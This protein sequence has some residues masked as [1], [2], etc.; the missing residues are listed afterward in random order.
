M[1]VV[2]DLSKHLTRNTCFISYENWASYDHLRPIFLRSGENN[3]IILWPPPPSPM[4][5]TSPGPQ[6]SSEAGYEP[7]LKCPG[8][9]NRLSHQEGLVDRAA[10]SPHLH[11]PRPI[12][13][14]YP[15]VTNGIPCRRAITAILS[16]RNSVSP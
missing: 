4:A 6:W 8:I 9:G 16:I 5:A 1:S 15:V 2:I 3:N 13:A 10:P 7:G 14:Q 12:Q 11:P